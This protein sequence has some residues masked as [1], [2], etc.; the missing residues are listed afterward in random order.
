MKNKKYNDI[1]NNKI[2]SLII[3][4]FLPIAI[5]VKGRSFVES[6]SGVMWWIL[7]K[8]YK[9]VFGSYYKLMKKIP[10][11]KIIVAKIENVIS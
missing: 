11:I 8:I 4:T 7:K 5:Y 6:K 2:V 3:S 10:G 1:C 9:W